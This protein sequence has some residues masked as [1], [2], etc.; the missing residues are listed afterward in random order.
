MN[1]QK[2]LENLIQEGKQ[3][4]IVLE[5]KLLDSEKKHLELQLELE[6]AKDTIVQEKLRVKGL[7]GVKYLKSA[8]KQND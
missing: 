7:E 2:E 4:H 8:Y 3:K 5:S 1:K 6:R